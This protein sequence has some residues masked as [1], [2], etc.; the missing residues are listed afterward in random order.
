MEE[1]TTFQ[2]LRHLFMTVFLHGFSAFI[3]VPVIT[4]VSMAALCPGKDECSLAIYLSGFQQAITGVGSLMMMPLVG[5]LSDKHGRK[6]LLTLPMALNI[7]PL[8]IL[9]YSRETSVFYIYYVLKTFTSIF[10]EGSVFCLALAYVVATTVAIFST[11]YMRIFLPDSIRDNSLV[12]S[13]VSTEKLSYVLLED[14]PG[15]RNQ[16]SRT[17]RSVRE[18]ASLMRSSVPL[19]QVAMV[20]FFSSLSE[21]GLHAS[22]MYYLKAKFQF[23]K[24]QFADLMIIFG[25]AGSVSQ[26]LFMP[27]LIPALKEEKL[28]SI[29]LFFGCAH[30]FLLGMAWSAWVPYMAAMFS[31]VSIFH[32]SCMRSIVSKQVTSYEQGKAQ[33]IISS[34]CSLANVISPLA[35]SPLTG[36]FLSERAPFHF[37]GFSLMCAGFT[38]TIAFILSLMIRATTPVAAMGSP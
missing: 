32:Q 20:S 30:M 31:L 2:G 29:G 27:I 38:M 7:L 6:S 9:A 17:V 4:D 10:C 28:L 34:I 19:F 33:G 12:T 24:D 15:H 35:F 5:S 1:T 13:I 22:S 23:N 11:V 26:L 37:P 14:Y 16:I 18:M 21:A 8:A 36:W 25:I 3:V